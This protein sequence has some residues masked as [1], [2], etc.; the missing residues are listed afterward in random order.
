MKTRLIAYVAALGV[1]VATVLAIAQTSTKPND[2]AERQWEATRD[3][4]IAAKL[5]KAKLAVMLAH[6]DEVLKNML[7]ARFEKALKQTQGD[8]L[9][10][11]SLYL[12]RLSRD[13][14]IMM[15]NEFKP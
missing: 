13:I 14:E 12:E 1:S 2:Q 3:R 5:D 11:I 15:R 9:D 10:H 6:R 8:R 7:D 4:T